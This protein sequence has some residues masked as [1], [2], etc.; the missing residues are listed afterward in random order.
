MGEERARRFVCRSLAG[1]H[2]LLLVERVVGERR[3]AQAQHRHEYSARCRAY[4]S[5]SRR[6]GQARGQTSNNAHHRWRAVIVLSYS[7]VATT[8][9]CFANLRADIAPWSTF[10]LPTP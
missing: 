6:A 3:R 8:E 10:P 5:I 1:G 2:R 4:E 7:A 9:N